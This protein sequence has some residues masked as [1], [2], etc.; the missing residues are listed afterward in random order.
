MVRLDPEE[1]R[2]DERERE[3]EGDPPRRGSSSIA[4]G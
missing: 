1:R 3:D 2:E 4:C